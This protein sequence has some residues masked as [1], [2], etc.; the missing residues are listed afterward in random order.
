MKSTERGFLKRSRRP[1]AEGDQVLGR[2]GR[3]GVGDDDRLDGLAPLLV[4]DADHAGFPHGGV[5]V[6]S[7][8]DL[9]AV[10]VEATRD[11]HV[12]LAVDEEEIAVLPHPGQVSGVHPAV[13]EGLR[14]QFRL[15]PVLLYA[16][17][18]AHDDLA[19]LARAQLPARLVHDAYLGVVRRTTA[20]LE[21]LGVLPHASRDLLAAQT[22]DH[23]GGLAEPVALGDDRAEE[24]HGVAQTLG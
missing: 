15:L 11:D 16:V 22:R 8:L 18:A 13:P 14:G 17:R 23:A 2:D 12:L 6:Q 9:G 7:G 20:G 3:T 1:A 24:L 4:G 5:F 10:D 21:Q 19:D